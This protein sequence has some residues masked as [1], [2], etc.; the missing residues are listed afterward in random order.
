MLGG[1]HA[2]ALQQAGDGLVE[3]GQRT[4]PRSLDTEQL[5][6]PLAVLWP[7]RRVGRHQGEQVGDPL[8]ASREGREPGQLEDGGEHQR[9]LG[10]LPSLPQRLLQ[11]LTCRLGADGIG[12]A[13]L[14]GGS[15]GHLAEGEPGLHLQR[16]LAQLGGDAE[17]PSGVPLGG[18]RV[19][20]GTR[21]R[22]ELQL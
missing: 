1:G 21:R 16:A 22:G 10:Q 5:A 8:A 3:A 4:G 6:R 15:G 20:G 11:Q 13:A 18:G 9:R 12:P 7:R 19:S 17:G 2:A 14:D